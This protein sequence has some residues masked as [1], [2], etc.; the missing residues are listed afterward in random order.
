MPAKIFTMQQCAC[1]LFF[2]PTTYLAHRVY[3]FC[4][5]GCQDNK[6][7]PRCDDRYEIQL[8]SI[9]NRN[10]ETFVLWPDRKLDHRNQYLISINDGGNRQS[11]VI[12]GDQEIDVLA[13]CAKEARAW[14]KKPWYGQIFN[15]YSYTATMYISYAGSGSWRIRLDSKDN[16]FAYH[17][18]HNTRADNLGKTIKP[19]KLEDVI[20]VGLKYS[21]CKRKRKR[22]GSINGFNLYMSE[23][24][25]VATLEVLSKFSRD[26]GESQVALI[27]S[28]ATYTNNDDKGYD[29]L[30]GNKRRQMLLLN[31]EFIRSS[32][33]LDIVNS[34][35]QY[36]ESL[37]NEN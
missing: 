2:Q 3:G 28:G 31:E 14:F 26:D 18:N 29:W 17:F 12:I 21:K 36:F 22:V 15:N 11:L 30:L 27:A 33:I 20:G 24:A 9:T 32:R 7:V 5:I 35:G 16:V 23:D 8:R 10:T 4:S 25:L 13:S 6:P 37:V 1:G 34:S 19:T